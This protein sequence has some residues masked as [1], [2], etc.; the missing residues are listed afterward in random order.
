MELTQYLRLFRKW[1]WLIAVVAFIGGGIAYIDAIRR[2]TLYQAESTISIGGYIDQPNPSQSQIYTGMSLATT[3]AQLVRTYSILQA[4][5]DELGLPISAEALHS[6]INTRIIE[7]TSLLVIGVTYPD[8][9]LAADIANTLTEQIIANSPSNL[10]TDQQAQITFAN[11]QIADLSAQLQGARE[12][13]AL[14]DSQLALATEP[15]A[16]ATLTDQRSALIDQINAAAS[17]IA[18]FSSTV[19][20]LQQRSNAVTIVEEARIPTGSTGAS[21]IRSALLGA[22]VGAALVIGVILLIEYMDDKIRTSDQAVAILKLPVLAAIQ[23]YGSKDYPYADMLV[24]TTVWSPAAEGY[25]VLRTNLLFASTTANEDKPV[26]LVTSCGPEEGKTVTISNLAASMAQAGMQ[27]LLI[28]ADLRRPRVHDIFGLPNEF[29]LTNLL[30][31]DPNGKDLANTEA[32]EENIILTGL[33]MSVQ[34]TAIPRLR[35][36][37]S[38]FIPSNPTEILGSA[39]M[40][41]WMHVFLNM[42]NV[43]AIL[44]DTPP[45]LV[46]A[47]TAV[48]AKA[49]DANVV[50]V[51]D[52]GRTRIAAARRMKEQFEQLDA[53][54]RGVVLNRVN[55]K[56]EHYG[57]GYGYGYGYYYSSQPQAQSNGHVPEGI[58][59]LK[60]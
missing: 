26:Y 39:L 6:I 28:D 46:A 45:A 4:T 32:V 12:Q 50:F 57:Y 19:T 44:F 23:K 24:P 34:Q 56:E 17:T 60:K 37:T 48:L 11:Q 21:P 9:T 1:A 41:R 36:I 58:E 38:G 18:T 35:V 3:Y 8:P 47:D 15:A 55:P 20:A 43:D 40:Q 7:G 25:R 22:M 30:F 52:A 13:V 5:I 54:V 33:K 49:I 27:V 14:L 2:P 10:T 16:L 53:K 42:P 29:G 59:A 31:A 51:L